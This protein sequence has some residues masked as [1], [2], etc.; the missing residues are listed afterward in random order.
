MECC[1]ARRSMSSLQAAGD[2][3]CFGAETGGRGGHQGAVR[4][5]LPA[6]AQEGSQCL[7]CRSTKR[8]RAPRA[9]SRPTSA[10]TDRATPGPPTD[11]NPLWR[12]FCRN[13]CAARLRPR[14]Q[15]TSPLLLLA[16]GG[17]NATTPGAPTLPTTPNNN[18]SLAGQTIP[19]RTDPEAQRLEPLKAPKG[20]PPD[21][22][23]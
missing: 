19:G 5:A 1:R 14:R 7:L 2:Q 17:C 23:P 9:G 20:S 16:R 18:K 13:A 15:P 22:A 4:Q 8:D 3:S 21:T 10:L 6:Q 11:P 12:E